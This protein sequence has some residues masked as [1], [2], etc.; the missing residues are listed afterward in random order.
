M[1][2]EEKEVSSKQLFNGRVVKLFVDEV[3][4][5]DHSHSVR[6]YMKHSGGAA[7]LFVKDEKVLL[8]RQYRYAYREEMWEIPAGKLEPNED[9]AVAAAREL[10][11]ETGY[12]A[13]DLKKLFMLYPTPGY[14]D[15][16]LHIYMATKCTQGT[17]HLDEDEFLNAEFVPLKD[18]IRMVETG[19]IHDAKTVAAILQYQLLMK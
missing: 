18:V 5:A 14:T 1:N 12:I 16:R 3:E 15:E 13:Q 4:L 9:P 7:V 10:E 6:E 2:L 8:V 17:R 11:E 19:E